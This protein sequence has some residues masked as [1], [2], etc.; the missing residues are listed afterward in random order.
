MQNY[1]EKRIKLKNIHS[2]WKKFQKLI[3]I[4]HRKNPKI[5]KRSPWKKSK[6]NKRRATLYS[7]LY[8]HCKPIPCNETRVF[9]VKFLSQGNPCNENRVLAMRKWVPCNEN[10]FFP[11]RKTS[12]GKPFSGPV[13]ALY[14]IAV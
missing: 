6:I 8:I 9:P 14:G 1:V 12:Q 4:A 10:R 2:T 5:N 7:G 13:L 3:S 11:V